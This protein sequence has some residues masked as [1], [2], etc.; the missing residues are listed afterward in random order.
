MS[1]HGYS[2]R[3]K[4]LT[5]PDILRYP[6]GRARHEEECVH[7][8]QVSREGQLKLEKFL[9]PGTAQRGKGRTEGGS[10]AHFSVAATTP[11]W[12][13]PWWVSP[14]WVIRLASRRGISGGAVLRELGRVPWIPSH[15]P[16]WVDTARFLSS[17][18]TVDVRWAEPIQSVTE[19]GVHSSMLLECDASQACHAAPDIDDEHTHLPVPAG[20]CI[21]LSTALS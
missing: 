18:N 20:A 4:G 5:S 14:W 6:Q 8:C 21:W 2:V 10:A 1:I 17:R 7:G 13:T 15:F 11:W 16:R 3:R 9:A 19:Y 12:V